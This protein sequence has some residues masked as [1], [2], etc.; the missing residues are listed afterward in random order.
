MPKACPYGHT[1]VYQRCILYYAGASQMCH[2]CFPCYRVTASGNRETSVTRVTRVTFCRSDG[3]DK[4]HGSGCH[5]HGVGL[6]D[7]GVGVAF[8]R[9]RFFDKIEV[10]GSSR[11]IAPRREAMVEPRFPSARIEAAEQPTPLAVGIVVK[12][13]TVS[14][15]AKPPCGDLHTRIVFVEVLLL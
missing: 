2:G 6:R 1:P 12:S 4:A 7:G 3:V 10:R 5:L 11:S 14:G 15:C 8:K 9:P 13:A